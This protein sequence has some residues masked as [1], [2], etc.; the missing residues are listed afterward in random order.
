MSETFKSQFTRIEG[1]S[2]RRRLPRLG[3]IRLGVKA[4]SKKT[5][6][7]YPKETE[8]FI[9]PAEVEKVYGKTPTVLDVMFPINDPEIVF[10]QAYKFYGSSKG[11]KCIGNGRIAHRANE[12]GTFTEIECPCEKLRT[13]DNPK[14][15]CSQRASLMVILPKVNLGG[16]YQIDIGSYHSIVDINS[17]IDYV[18]ALLKEALGVER[19]ALIPLV[20]K[21]EPRETHHDNKKQVHY[22]LN[23]TCNLTID[24]LN[25]IKSDARI[26]NP[27]PLALPAVEEI[28]PKFDEGAAVVYDEENGN[29]QNE[30]KSD[31]PKKTTKKEIEEPPDNTPDKKD[32]ATQDQFRALAQ[33]EESLLLQPFE[34]YLLNLRI[35][36][37][38]ITSEKAKNMINYWNEETMKRTEMKTKDV[39]KFYRYVNDFVQKLIN[40]YPAEYSEFIGG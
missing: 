28:N 23:L 14:G 37:P 6:H 30:E 5:G 33:I 16:I 38:D 1:L 20:L 12:D 9:V 7:E 13:E 32:L 25:Q 17:G 36:D 35:A 40:D 39:K 34:K 18:K 22:T 26:L 4:I 19:F 31:K 24:Q 15:E 10:P 8:Y 11:L 21:R 3:K 29:K 27:E 2:S